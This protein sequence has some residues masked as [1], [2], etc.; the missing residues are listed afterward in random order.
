MHLK[1]LLLLSKDGN[2]FQTRSKVKE[3]ALESFVFLK[4]NVVIYIS[5][6]DD[7]DFVKPFE[8]ERMI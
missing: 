6:K 8:R 7:F 5:I 2:C 1:S 3:V 4:M